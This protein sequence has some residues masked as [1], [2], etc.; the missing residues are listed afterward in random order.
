MKKSEDLNFNYLVICEKPDAA[1]RIAEAL[2]KYQEYSEK[3]TNYY[4]VK[5]SDKR[6]IVCSAL[7]HLYV[8]ADPTNRRELYP[9]LDVE[10]LPI[11]K[12]DRKK[13][14][15]K[16]RIEI[17][18]NLAKRAEAYINACDFDLEG[19]TIGYNILKYACGEKQNLALRAK[20]STLTKDEL[21]EAFKKAKVGLGGNLAEAG[22]ARHILD[23]LYGINLSRAFS[24]AFYNANHRYRLISIG[25]VQG[26]TLSFLV[27]REI[28]IRSFV[29]LPYWGLEALV[30]LKDGIRVVAKYEHD[31]IERLMLAKKIKEECEGKRGKV[32]K[33]KKSLINISPPTPF[34]TGDLQKEAYRLFGFSPSQTLSIAERLYLDALISYPRTSS[35]KL[36]PSINY[37]RIMK[38]LAQ[39]ESYREDV[40]LLLKSQLKPNE[41]EKDD[42]AHPAIYPTG[43]LPKRELDSR[44]RKL[45]DLIVR[46]FFSVFGEPALRER[47]L[48]TLL[49]KDYLFKLSGRRTVKEGWIRFYREYTQMEDIPL[50]DMK[51]GEEV[52]FLRID[53]LEKFES[54]PSRYNQASL[55]DKMEREGIGTK[56]TRAEIIQTLYERGYVEGESINVNDMGFSVYE[57]INSYI[58]QI[59]SVEMTRNMEEKLES[60]E[61]GKVRGEKVIEDSFEILLPILEKIKEKEIVIGQ[62][63]RKG[64]INMIF[65][66]NLLGACPLCKKGNLTIIRSRR[67]HKRFVICTTKGC[68]ASAPLPQRGFIKSTNQL[69]QECRWPI[70]YVKLSKIP[71][72]LCI[73]IN[74]PTKSKVK[75]V[76]KDGKV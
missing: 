71:W 35:Q 25:R 5:N 8:V 22:R 37:E 65:K 53:L 58:P 74:C 7:G 52:N 29:P 47:I 38:S 31:R 1:K 3:G 34:N 39:L 69:C 63:I 54:A 24:E 68:K 67:T 2:G 36:P 45:Y 70:I 40:S 42:P 27:N 48:A 12:V 46:R 60:V 30:E 66:Q 75:E 61:R 19:E 18:A 4:L 64:L 43:E 56:V 44:E 62:E 41:G 11:Y 57:A 10:W 15:L 73:N 28:E 55:L 9:V 16:D 32:E 13:A 72:K 59:L 76:V 50:P 14:Q 20:F 26:P 49:V 21:Q 17:I 33:L 6:Y 51:E 23:F